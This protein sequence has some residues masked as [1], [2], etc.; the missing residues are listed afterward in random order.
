MITSYLAAAASAAGRRGS[1]AIELCR[2]NATCTAERAE[3]LAEIRC[4]GDIWM[5]IAFAAVVFALVSFIMLWKWKY[6]V[7]R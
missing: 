5:A 7:R 6:E 1:E 3:K 4:D 2:Q